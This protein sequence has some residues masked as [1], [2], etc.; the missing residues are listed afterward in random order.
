MNSFN[1]NV[2]KCY[3]A[4][5]VLTVTQLNKWGVRYHELKLGKPI[6]DLWVDDKGVDINDFFDEKT[7]TSS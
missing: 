1:G 3:D 4:Y 5:L 6:Y 2:D 7:R